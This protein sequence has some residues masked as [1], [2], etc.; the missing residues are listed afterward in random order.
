VVLC[1]DE[2]QINVRLS[3]Q[4]NTNFTQNF[5][6]CRP[7]VSA[8]ENLEKHCISQGKDALKDTYLHDTHRLEIALSALRKREEEHSSIQ[9]ED[10]ADALQK[11][12][13]QH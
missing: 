1:Y 8:Q 6:R 7:R 11:T 3:W 10:Q 9:A 4:R 12:M 5:Q 13:L 2:L